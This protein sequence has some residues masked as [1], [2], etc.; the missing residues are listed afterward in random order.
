MSDNHKGR[1][2]TQYGKNGEKGSNPVAVL[3]A[4]GQ[5]LKVYLQRPSIFLLNSPEKTAVNYVIMCCLTPEIID[6]L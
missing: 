1:S 3:Q 4:E 5:V 2:E 6:N